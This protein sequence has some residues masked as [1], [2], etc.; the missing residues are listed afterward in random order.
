MRRTSL[1]GIALMVLSVTFAALPGGASISI[2]PRYVEQIFDET[3]VNIGLIYGQATNNR[4]ELQDLVLD[5][6]E[7]AGDAAE[8]R[9]AI[10]FAH[11]GGF[12]GGSRTDAGI[13]TLATELAKYGYV[14]A[15]ISY[16]IRPPGTPGS[17]TMQDLIVSSLAGQLPGAMHDAQHDLQAAVRWLRA[18]AADH[19]IDPATIVASGISAGASMALEAGYNP[20]DP[21]SSNDIIASSHIAAALSVSGAT[22]PRRIE[23]ARP[24]VAMFNGTHD[25]TAP[26]P[27]AVLACGTAMALTN[28]CE[29][30]TY[31]GSGHDLSAH[32]TDI[33]RY[34]AVFLCL[35]VV[36]CSQG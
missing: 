36:E 26:Y 25:S 28:V 24:P 14:T 6:Y 7:P 2:G 9:P 8:M 16:R 19:R 34:S 4:G 3:T 30:T 15:S 32:T 33:I 13:V 23:P 35:H 17:P 22:D 20:D 10:V 29:L 5:L 31:P 12:T 1:V 11:G 27:T 18:K 21:G